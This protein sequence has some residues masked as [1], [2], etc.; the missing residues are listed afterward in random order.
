MSAFSIARTAVFVAL[1][2]SRNP[3]VRQAVRNAPRAVGAMVSDENKRAVYEAAKRGARKAGEVT[4][5]VVPP[6]R[7]F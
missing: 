4:A 2:A 5:K 7:Y 6:N 1:A 3:M